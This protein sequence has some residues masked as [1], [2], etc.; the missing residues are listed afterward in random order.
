MPIEM[1]QASYAAV[2]FESVGD[3]IKAA[4]SS[5]PRSAVRPVRADG[6]QRPAPASPL[7]NGSSL[8]TDE[9]DADNDD[10]TVGC[11]LSTSTN[12]DAARHCHGRHG[13]G[14]RSIQDGGKLL[15]RYSSDGKAEAGF[16]PPKEFDAQYSSAA[17]G[18]P[19]FERRRAA[20]GDRCVPYPTPL[21]TPHSSMG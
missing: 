18:D 16:N 19:V 2:K 15:V 4:P 20:L 3:S 1:H 8:Q 10:D 9:R 6:A 11:V 5:T 13:C 7:R 17:S 14:E 12:G 21:W